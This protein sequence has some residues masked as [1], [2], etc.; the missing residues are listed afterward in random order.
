MSFIKKNLSSWFLE[1]SS[2]GVELMTVS[3]MRYYQWGLWFFLL[4]VG[5]VIWGIKL[6]DKRFSTNL[7]TPGD[8]ACLSRLRLKSPVRIQF[9]FNYSKEPFHIFIIKLKVLHRWV[10]VDCTQCTTLFIRNWLQWIQIPIL[11]DCMFEGLFGI[12]TTDFEIYIWNDRY[13]SADDSLGV[14]WML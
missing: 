7:L 14:C 1:M 8:F 12:Y 6:C 2:F 5:K 10:L 3:L 4:L 11:L 13:I 9:L